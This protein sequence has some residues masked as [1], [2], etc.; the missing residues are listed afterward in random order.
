MFPIKKPADE[1]GYTIVVRKDRDRFMTA[2][3]GDQLMLVFQCDL[4]HFRNIQDRDPDLTPGTKD[5]LLSRCIR[6]ANLDA[7]WARESSTVLGNARELGK[8]ADNSDILGIANYFPKSGP[9]PVK[10]QQGMRVAC[11]VLLRSLD[12]GRN[13]ENVQFGTA[14]K[15]R[16]VFSNMWHASLEGGKNAVIQRDTTKLFETSCPTNG[17]W[18]ERFMLEMHKRQGDKSFPDLAISIEVML[19]LMRRFENAWDNAD[20][21]ERQQEAVLFPALFSVVTYCAGL[22]GE[23]TPL[24]DLAGTRRVFEESGRHALPHVVVALIG[25]FKNEVGELHHKLPLAAVTASGLGPRLWVGRMLAWY[26]A[27]GTVNG[28][29]FRNFKNGE[30]ARASRYEFDILLVLDTIK[31]ENGDLISESIDVFERYGVSRSFRRGSNTHAINQGVLPADVDHNNRWAREKRA[32]GM[33]PNLG[34]Q[35]HYA[36]VLQMLPTLLRYSSAL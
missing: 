26:A 3:N 6:R 23:E 1:E 10:D 12:P 5:F 30:S 18:F 29:V 20:G 15:A 27:R 2:R 8:M 34:M 17:H 11:T 33:A 36:D 21:N 28:P 9:F 24:M 31:R 32:R 25:R 35:A 13:E 16:S 19:E 7:F 14:R 4:C 22:R